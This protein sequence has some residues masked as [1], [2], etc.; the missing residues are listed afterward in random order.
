MTHFV[1]TFQ[2][3]T[4]TLCIVLNTS[5]RSLLCRQ[6][7][8]IVTWSY[9][10]STLCHAACGEQ[11]K[12][13]NSFGQVR[14]YKFCHMQGSVNQE[15]SCLTQ[16]VSV[17]ERLLNT[18]TSLR[19]WWSCRALMDD[20]TFLPVLW[21]TFTVCVCPLSETSRFLQRHKGDVWRCFLFCVRNSTTSSESFYLNFVLS[22]FCP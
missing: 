10:T 9:K 21:G 7:Q 4:C 1:S 5:S 6:T 20:C 12:A 15:V 18:P 2:T 13:L 14:G 19:C 11:T 3:A 16:W 22:T 8:L 17:R